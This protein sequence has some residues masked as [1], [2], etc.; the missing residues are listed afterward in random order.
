MA[1]SV[2]SRHLNFH[3]VGSRYMFFVGVTQYEQLTYNKYE[4]RR[5]WT[6][7]FP[8]CTNNRR[9]DFMGV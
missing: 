8:F 1:S 2:C 6:R 9:G 7:L 3:A 4:L 5:K